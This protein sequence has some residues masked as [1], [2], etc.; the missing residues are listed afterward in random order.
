M[1]TYNLPPGLR[2]RL[3]KP[4]GRLFKG[5][6][7]EGPAF[8]ELVTGA[9]IIV[10]VGD[11]V[12]DTIGKMGRTPEV[13]VVDG[14]ERREKREP[15]GVAH[16]RLIR[17]KNPAGQLTSEAMEAVRSAF[18]GEKPARVLVEGEEDLLAMAAIAFAPQSAVV[19]YGQPGVGVVAVVVD[20][21]ARERTLS[22][23]DEMGIPRDGLKPGAT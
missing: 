8:R 23:M 22:I 9:Q 18:L 19:L 2:P 21:E 15:P 3:A 13:Q 12:T 14:V 17:A 7:V 5:S 4:L 1:T 6:E 20:E 11:R 10:T 16:A